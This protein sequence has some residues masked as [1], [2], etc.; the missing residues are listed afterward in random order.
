[1][2]FLVYIVWYWND[3]GVGVLFW[4]RK[5]FLLFFWLGVGWVI[6]NFIRLFF[7]GWFNVYRWILCYCIVSGSYV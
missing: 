6:V 1:M 3:D 2:Y 4:D 7:S 5:L